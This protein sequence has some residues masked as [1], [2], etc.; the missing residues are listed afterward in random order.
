[1]SFL[2][3]EATVQ[4][5][6]WAETATAGLVVATVLWAGLR[7][8]LTGRWIGW[9]ALAVFGAPAL[10]WFRA[11]YARARLASGRAGPGFVEIDE[12]RIV[13]LG[14]EYGGL[15]DLDALSAV[16]IVTTGAGPSAPDVFWVLHHAD[17][18]PVVIPASAEGAGGLLDAFAALPGFSYE[19]VIEAMGSTED[20]AFT[21]WRSGG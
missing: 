17:G 11:A 5:R 1:M 7:L 20:A 10:L 4:L 16:Q 8:G 14:P 12:R 6:R 15:A 13:Y 3:P 18:P 19:R 21:I 2:R 9:V